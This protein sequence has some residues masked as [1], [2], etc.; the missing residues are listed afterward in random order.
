MFSVPDL[1][2]GYADLSPYID[3]QT[4]R[5]HHDKHHATYVKN[6]NDV[7]SGAPELS[8]FSA[9][10]LLSHL[11]TVP[12]SIRTAVKNNVGGHVNHTL[13]WTSMA[14]PSGDTIPAP[15]GTLATA[16]DTT[17]GSFDAFREQFTKRGLAR[18]GS[19]WVWLVRDGGA[20]AIVDTANQDTPMSDG[21]IPLLPLDVW[22]HAYYLTYQNRRAEY[23]A[24]WWHVVNWSEVEKRYADV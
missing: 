2:Y 11:E 4:M 19:G 6:A 12:E 24:A 7:I 8:K 20:I 14:K 10:E 21:K 3:E 15:K 17:F 13:F 22:E 23:I 16:I 18:F 5:I 9:E 1:P